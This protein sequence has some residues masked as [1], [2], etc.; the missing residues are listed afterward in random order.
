MSEQQ[1]VK[2]EST[3]VAIPTDD[4]LK[5]FP[6][7]G[8][9]DGVDVRPPK[10][11]IISQA[12]LFRMPTDEKVPTV[13]GIVV[14]AH[15]CNGYWEKDMA[16][17]GAG[18]PPDC[19]SMDG[20]IP[21]TENPKCHH[22]AECQ[23]NQFKSDGGRGKACKNMQRLYVQ[24]NDSIIPF[25]ITLSPTSLRAWSDYMVI[26][27][28]MAK[29]PYQTVITQISLKSTKNKDGIEFSQAEF[30]MVEP[31]NNMAKLKQIASISANVKGKKVEVA[32]D[33]YIETDPLKQ[34]PGDAF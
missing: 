18:N 12:Q 21:Y 7:M 24:V 25:L 17:G 13:V 32:A 22:C 30:K 31:I 11:G 29:R 14:H 20:I 3:E 33:E 27:T 6:L 23:F 2:K 4:L 16:E 8:N 34:N 1:I 15:R 28:S 10:I 26:L 9:I 5:M 19:A